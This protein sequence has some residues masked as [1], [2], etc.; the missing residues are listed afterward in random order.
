MTDE[1]FRIFLFPSRLGKMGECAT[2]R[3]TKLRNA[4]IS[5]RNGPQ[6]LMSLASRV[7]FLAFLTLHPTPVRLPGYN[8]I[9]GNGN[10]NGNGNTS[11]PY[12]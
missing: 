7:M 8:D 6:K 1:N 2:A 3:N 4:N 5:V 9:E 10:G 12:S 11:K